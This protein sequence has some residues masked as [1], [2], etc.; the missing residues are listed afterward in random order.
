MTLVLFQDQPEVGETGLELL[1]LVSA[2]EAREVF[3]LGP[4]LV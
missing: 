4:Y 2:D 1:L 3:Y